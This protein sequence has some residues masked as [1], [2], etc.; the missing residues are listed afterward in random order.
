MPEL[1]KVVDLYIDQG[2]TRLVDSRNSASTVPAQVAP[3]A[4]NI[5][6]RA[7]VQYSDGTAFPIPDGTVFYFAIDQTY[8][9]SASADLVTSSGGD[10]NVSGDWAEASLSAGYIS[11]RANLNTT[12]LIAAMGTVANKRMV[13]E[14]WMQSPGSDYA[15]LAQWPITILNVVGSVTGTPSTPGV[16]YATLDALNG[17][18][19]A[20]LAFELRDGNRVAVVINGVE[21]ATIG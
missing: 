2:N 6:F 15:L 3:V 7:R 18:I 5:L 12:Q 9:P 19:P 1:R 14:L 20:G 8:G 16:T 10:F 11:W 13:A 4:S 21:V 17:R